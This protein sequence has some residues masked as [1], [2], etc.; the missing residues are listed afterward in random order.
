[1]KN[2]ET[3]PMPIK[4]TYIYNGKEE[5][6]EITEEELKEWKFE[7]SYHFVDL[8]GNEISDQDIENEA[9]HLKV[10]TDGKR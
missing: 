4:G 8:E 1:M 9:W 2:K 6:E 10:K 7:V 3:M 5:A